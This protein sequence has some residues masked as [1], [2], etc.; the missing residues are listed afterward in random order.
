MLNSNKGSSGGK[1]QTIRLYTPAYNPNTP[2]QQLTRKIFGYFTKVYFKGESKTIGAA[3]FDIDAYKLELANLAKDRAYRGVSTDGA[4]A[5]VQL[6]LGAAVLQREDGDLVEVVTNGV[7]PQNMT[8]EGNLEQ[9][10]TVILIITD[11]IST[12]TQKDRIGFTN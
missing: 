8:I 12:M 9:F 10:I 2:A 4:N 5:G 3:V 6:S 11:T 1:I 7:L